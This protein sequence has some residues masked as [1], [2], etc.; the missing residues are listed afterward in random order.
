MKRICTLP[1]MA[2]RFEVTAHIDRATSVQ[3][4][5]K[6]FEG[7]VSLQKQGRISLRIQSHRQREY[8]PRVVRL[9]LL[10]GTTARDV[11]I[12]LSDQR[13][14]VN[15]PDLE[16][17]DVYFKRSFWP[18]DLA[19]ISTNLRSKIRPFGLNN[20]TA[21]FSTAARVLLARLQSGV[22]GRHLAQDARH[23]LALPAPAAF[24]CPPEVRAEPCIFFQTRVWDPP[25]EDPL[26]IAINEERAAL[27][28]SLRRAFGRRFV[29]G[30]IP[31]PYALKHYP[32]TITTLDFSMRSYAQ[33]L[34]KPLVAIYSRGL[35]H[36]VAFKM[37][38]YL[39]ASR[40]IVGHRPQVTLPCQ[41]VEG[42]NYLGFNDPEGCIAKCETLLCNTQ[43]GEAMRKENWDYYRR[44]VEPAAQMLRT[45]ERAFERE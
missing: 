9:A 21:G 38:E 40:A 26:T 5:S 24:E 25:N 22:G 11:A 13:S 10:Q 45:L 30:I 42:A 41:L 7:L 1:A 3:E 12:D 33:L 35:H 31:S 16:R 36:S 18:E 19:G 39:A 43:A 8:Y 37:A 20:P 29:G 34:K 17:A 32:E 14:L 23:L 6:I 28:V 15:L 2:A 44:E 4:T 27:V